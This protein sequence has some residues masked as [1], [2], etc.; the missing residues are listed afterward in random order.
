MSPSLAETRQNN[1][2]VIPSNLVRVFLWMTGAMVFFSAMAVAIRLLSGKLAV[3]EMLALRNGLSLIILSLLALARPR[4]R[5]GYFPAHAHLHLVRI[6]VHLCAQ[7]SWTYGVTLLPLATVFALEFTSPG[8]VVLLAAVFLKERLTV[9]RI[10]NVILG[11]I[12][13]LIIV[14]P[15]SEAFQPA[16]LFVLGAAV[17]FAVFTTITKQLAATQSAFSIIFWMSLLQAPLAYALSEPLFFLKLGASDIPAALLVGVAGLSSHF[18]ITM[19]FKSGDASLV[20]PFDFLRLPLIAVIGW[21]LFGEL[22]D[23]YVFIGGAAIV[24]GVIWN[25]WGEAKRP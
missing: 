22:P 16:A 15:G 13:I 17:G 23:I 4:L 12:G 9:G 14:R 3:F 24:A 7:Y 11:F 1:S 19:A 21:W 6:I 2:I 18:C 8:W 5:P 10:A 20:V 25:L